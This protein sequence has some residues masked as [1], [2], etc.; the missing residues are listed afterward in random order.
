MEEEADRIYWMIIRQLLLAVLDRRV[1]KEVGIDGPMHV[2]GNRVI[3][4][5]LEQMGDLASHIAQEAL[6][7]K[8]DA[9]GVDAKLTKG[10]LDFS[11]R[12]GLLIEDSLK[13]WMKGDVKNS[14]DWME[15]GAS[16]EEH[17]R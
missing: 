4:K 3:A 8:G 12:G 10:I 13:A 6:R 16:S 11:D 2:V 1:A 5:S 15:R 9:K 14:E 17:E 7:L